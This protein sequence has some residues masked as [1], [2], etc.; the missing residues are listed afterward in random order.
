MHPA[1]QAMLVTPMQHA[2]YVG[3]DAYGKPTHAALHTHLGKLEYRQ[4][5]VVDAAGI[6]RVSRAR[7]FFDA[8]VI[9]D[10]KDLVVLPDTTRPP[11]LALYEVFNVDGSRSHWQIVF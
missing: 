4:R 1:L 2:S 11:I 5:K 6:E 8:T 10:L 9:M 3:Q 7:V